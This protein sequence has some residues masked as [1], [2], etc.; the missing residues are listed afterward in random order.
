MYT[1]LDGATS[2]K[3]KAVDKTI[4]EWVKFANVTFQKTTNVASAKIR[5]SFTNLQGSSWSAIG[6]DSLNITDT[7]KPTL[8]LG[9]IGDVEDPSPEDA[10]TIL[11]EF[12]HALGMM[13]EHQSPARGERIHLKELAVYNYYR[14][15]LGNNNSL[16]KTQVIDQYNLSDISNFSHLDLK[17]IMMYVHFLILLN[18]F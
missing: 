7:S 3:A 6:Q 5:I 16:V 8:N 17:S 4:Q 10:G 12:G 15:L 1:Y 18:K 9:W 13:H 11:H 2:N 14:P